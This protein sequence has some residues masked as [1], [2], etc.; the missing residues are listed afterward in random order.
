MV[1]FVSLLGFPAVASAQLPSS[2]PGTIRNFEPVGENALFNRGMNSA[3]AVYHNYLYITNRTDASPGHL[4][5]GILVVDIA[6]PARPRVVAEIGPPAAA[7][8][9]ESTREARV[10]PQ[11]RLLIVQNVACGVALHSCTPTP[12]TPTFRFFDLTGR[13][14]ANPKLVSTYV[15]EHVPHE[16]VLW[17]DPERPDRALLYY[18][19]STTS[20][21]P[22]EAAITVVDISEARAGVFRVV[23]RWTG[24]HLYGA[25]DRTARDIFV[26]SLDVSTDGRRAYVA[27]WGGGMVVLDTSDLANDQPNA[28]LRLLTP[29][30]NAPLWPNISAHAIDRVPG[31]P[32]VL[33]GDEVYGTYSQG[34]APFFVK[35]RQ[36]C[37][38]GWVHLVDISD[39]SRP[40][41]VGEFRIAENTEAFCQRAEGQDP[42]S[43]FSAHNM[44]A[45]RDVGLATWYA[46]GVRA[47]SLADPARST[48]TAVFMPTP[49]V[50]VA[51][52][53]PA[54]TAGMHK[55]AMWSFPIIK[56]GLLYV[57]DVRNGLFVLRYTGEGAGQVDRT[58]FR[59]ANSNLSETCPVATV[60]PQRI[61]EGRQARVTVNV[62]L[63]GQPVDRAQV[64]LAGPSVS[65]TAMTGVT[66][67]QT[68]VVR[69]MRAGTIAVRV[70]N[71]AKHCVARV[72]VAEARRGQAPGVELTGRH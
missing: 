43:T 71:V 19:H 32:L 67:R 66:G 61:V 15:P 23:A 62:R 54:T 9:G 58:I 60:R 34:I 65:R 27:H 8:V 36:G 2:T 56:N 29:P 13:N 7:N 70:P 18:S 52:E 57:A 26:H 50:S 1:A 45:L 3:T 14:A 53:D 46:G 72:R 68:F 11:R 37:P 42:R 17:V 41:V 30:A 39:E 24:T 59:E 28:E 4:H 55:I 33:V 40:R 49:L 47:F 25:A 48:E 64:R 31:R 63:F 44:V 10:W 22:N 12:T 69:P 21:D 35:E 51:T 5:P 16:F 20:T 38:W 6:R